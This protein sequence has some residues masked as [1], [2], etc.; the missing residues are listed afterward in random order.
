MLLL[1]NKK[2]QSLE[3]KVDQVAK[4]DLTLNFSEREVKD[5]GKL[6]SS[7]GELV[8]NVKKL[9][10][11]IN[12]AN[13]KNVI[14]TGEIESNTKQIF[15]A[16]QEISQAVMDIAS[17]ATEQNEALG[18]MKKV[19][20]TMSEDM[21][22]ILRYSE[23]TET[24]ANN[25]L[26][27]VHN[28]VQLLERII[29]SYKRNGQWSEA[30]GEKMKNLETQAN[31]I[32]QI[33]SLVAGISD[34]TNLLALNAS[35]EAA[36][37]GDMGK[38]FSVVAEEVKKLATE[39][40]EH[41]GDIEKIIYEMV[42]NTN[43]IAEEI[44]EQNEK[45][46]EELTLVNQSKEELDMI[47]QST[48]ETAKAIGT[49][50]NLAKNQYDLVEKVK[51]SIDAIALAMENTSSFSQEA[52][53]SSQEQTASMELI[54]EDI[55]KLGAM[56][57]EIDQLIEGFV[58]EFKITEETRKI[59]EAGRKEVKSIADN[60]D[61]RKMNSGVFRGLLLDRIKKN[62]YFQ[63]I[64]IMD[65][66]GDLRSIAIKDTTEELEGNFKH[67]PYFKESI[68]GK[69]FTS[70]PYISDYSYQYCV[71]VAVPVY[72]YDQKIIGIVMGDL[73]LE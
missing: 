65:K 50:R 1:H 16:S 40:A 9:V 34:N 18:K 73:L 55:K 24:M 25:T 67:R 41:S 13:E 3:K 5:L 58:Q 68:Q 4:G 22:G 57:K 30:L 29:D 17:E 72:D 14:F 31:D 45:I 35:I 52:A 11:N 62:P 43:R 54:F 32:Q 53:S 12:G 42:S 2:I 71:T 21:E 70:K 51:G 49:I 8:G 27:V 15:D 48:E 20:E 44:E 28:S 37:A 59:M 46:T 7:L 60:S 36:R 66:E 61:V 47:V 19:S 23:E 10:G 39:S 38:G 56:T 33:T 63:L 6:E 26:K 64:S 69:N